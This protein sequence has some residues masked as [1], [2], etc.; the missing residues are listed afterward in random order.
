MD[1]SKAKIY[2]IVNDIDNE[3]YVGSTTQALCKRMAKH[4]GEINTKA[5]SHRKLYQHMKNK[6]VQ[7]FRIELIK[8]FPCDNKEQMTAEEGKY[9][10]ELKPTLNKKIEGRTTKEWIQDNKEHLN[11][12]RKL[13]EE[14]IKAYSKHYR[15][16]NK[17]IL[18]EKQQQPYNCVCGSDITLNNKTR[19]LKSKKHQQFINENVKTE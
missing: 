4:R 1:Y 19:H 3:I 8:E 7:H 13:N 17:A 15:M 16:E 10:R 11:E 18:K 9:I 5:K 12:Y 14:K 6:G 2:Q